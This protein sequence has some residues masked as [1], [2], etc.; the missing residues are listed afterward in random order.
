MEKIT[1]LRDLNIELC[2]NNKIHYENIEIPKLR[3]IHEL[4]GNEECKIVKCFDVYYLTFS[5]L[6]NI[7][8]VI[9]NINNQL[10]LSF[11][12]VPAANFI[13]LDKS[14]L[15]Y[16]QFISLEL[17]QGNSA[18]K[19]LYRFLS[20]ILLPLFIVLIS[21]FSDLPAIQNTINSILSAVSIF[22]AIFTLFVM[23][24][25]YVERKISYLFSKGKINYYF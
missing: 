11:L 22:V 21:F 20:T 15:N 2:K 12:K 3:S 18:Y 4:L 19:K 9:K 10:E 17:F 5:S 24:N 1:N 6:R 8:F 14:N 23:N 7:Q 13:N 25:E 16:I